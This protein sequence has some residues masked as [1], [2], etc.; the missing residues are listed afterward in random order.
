MGSPELRSDREIVV[1]AVKENGGALRYAAECLRDD[2]EI[3]RAAR[4]QSSSSGRASGAS[5]SADEKNRSL[6][7][8]LAVGIL[9]AWVATEIDFP[10]KG[11]LIRCCIA[12][13]ILG[14]GFYS[15]RMEQSKA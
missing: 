6:T 5:N 7:I 3:K 13:C 14:A 1:A 8:I 10:Y 11:I 2:R 15:G 9:L 4:S 12:V